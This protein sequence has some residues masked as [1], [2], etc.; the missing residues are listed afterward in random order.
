LSHLTNWGHTVKR[1][2]DT[3]LTTAQHS[4]NRNEELEA[5][6]DDNDDEISAP[7]SANRNQALVGSG[8]FKERL[9]THLT[10]QGARRAA[11]DS[12]QCCSMTTE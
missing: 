7:Q 4:A 11:H 1:T 12:R 8:H 5:I 10:A 6:Y 2:S 3:Y 9:S